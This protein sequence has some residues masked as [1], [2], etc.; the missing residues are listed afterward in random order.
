MTD[1]KKHVL[2]AEDDAFLAEIMQRVLSERGLR[3]SV[4]RDGQEAID[5]IEKERPSLLLLDLLMP[6][7]DGY[8]VLIHLQEKKIVLPVIVLS[9][10]SDKMNGDRC[11]Q[12]GVESYFVKSDMDEDQLWPLVDGILK[13]N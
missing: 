8:G 3:V 10:L 1:T 7:V 6:N 9:N 5:A 11:R 2:I 13:G 12:L 4:A